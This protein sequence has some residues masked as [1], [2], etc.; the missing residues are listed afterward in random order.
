MLA[1][2]IPFL[3]FVALTNNSD[4]ALTILE[5]IALILTGFLFRAAANS[6]K[7]RVLKSVYGA[8]I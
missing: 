1:S 7:L 6:E 3:I 4:R 5:N 2:M 8:V